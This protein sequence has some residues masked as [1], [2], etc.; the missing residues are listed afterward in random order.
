MSKTSQLAENK[1][2]LLYL[3][4]KMGIPLSNSEICQFA[5][6]KNYMD[7][8][9]I[10]QYLSELEE[11]GFLDKSKDNNITRYTITED[12]SDVLSYFIKHI[13]EYAKNDIAQYVHENGKRIKAEFEI[14]ANYF[15]E[16]NNEYLVKCGL[17]DTD[18]IN[19]M[20]VSVMVPTKEQARKICQNWKGNVN[21]LY[22]GILQTLITGE[23]EKE[24]VNKK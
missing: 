4:A 13:S 6:E 18:G 7:Y 15:L 5:L 22:G 21:R 11:S 8:F 2:I 19:L 24:S 3:V 14:T 23:G 16:M 20:E 9:S 17:Y 12:G 10:Q 1:L